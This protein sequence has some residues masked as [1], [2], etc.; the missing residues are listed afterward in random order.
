MK[1]FV[2]FA[3]VTVRLLIG[4]N[5]RSAVS[6]DTMLMPSEVSSSVKE[7]ENE[8]SIPEEKD[9][10]PATE[11]PSDESDANPEIIPIGTENIS[12]PQ[13]ESSVV[14]PQEPQDD[15]ESTT[16]TMDK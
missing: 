8:S 1:E 7:S 12:A 4:C 14:V 15:E 16:P 3:L 10:E 2:A 6:T 11:T 13:A 9:T 5:N